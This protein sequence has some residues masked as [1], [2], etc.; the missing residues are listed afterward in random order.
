MGDNSGHAKSDWRAIVAALWHVGALVVPV[1]VGMLVL[2]G[3]SASKTVAP[4]DPVQTG[5]IVHR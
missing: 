3:L 4:L 5:S 1:L 2:A